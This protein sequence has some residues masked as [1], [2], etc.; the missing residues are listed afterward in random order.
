MLCS[1]CQHGTTRHWKCGQCGEIN[2]NHILWC[3]CQKGLDSKKPKSKLEYK[4][5]ERRITP[6][7]ARGLL[8]KPATETWES[9][10]EEERR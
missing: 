9:T 6:D 8:N 1:M 10:N 7:G 5:Q 4:H 3:K 2:C